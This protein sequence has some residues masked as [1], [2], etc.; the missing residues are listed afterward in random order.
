MPTTIDSLKVINASI[1]NFEK[2][3][4][5]R[6]SGVF[7]VARDGRKIEFVDHAQVPA[8][9]EKCLNLF[10]ENMAESSR[11]DEIALSAALFWMGFIAIH[12]FVD[13]NGQT[14]KTVIEKALAKRQLRMITFDLIDRYLI[15][16]DLEEDVPVLQK[17]FIAS[18][19]RAH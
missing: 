19:E 8:L 5:F 6:S 10:N 4:G 3:F 15:E 2:P 9:I 1:N 12:P 13:G 18:I 17:L 16:G 14:A 7:C 11:L